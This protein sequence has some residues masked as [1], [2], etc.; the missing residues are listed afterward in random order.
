MMEMEAPV[1]FLIFLSIQAVLNSNKITIG[2]AGIFHYSFRKKKLTIF[3][4]SAFRMELLPFSILPSK[5]ERFLI[6]SIHVYVMEDLKYSH[7][8]FEKDLLR[9]HSDLI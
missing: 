8:L 1:Y 9:V 5:V 7:R 3:Y 4:I 2:E 6:L